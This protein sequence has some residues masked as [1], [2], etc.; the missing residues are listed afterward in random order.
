MNGPQ[1]EE[2]QSR[3]G[4]LGGNK[5]VGDAMRKGIN[6]ATTVNKGSKER[7][8]AGSPASGTTVVGSSQALAGSSWWQVAGVSVFAT[9]SAAHQEVDTA[10]SSRKKTTKMEFTLAT[11][12]GYHRWLFLSRNMDLTG[13]NR[14]L[15]LPN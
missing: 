13:R 1:E 5:P 10:E 12:P 3:S 8:G 11:I 7:V 15:D 9:Q 4:G 2:N 14:V 6:G